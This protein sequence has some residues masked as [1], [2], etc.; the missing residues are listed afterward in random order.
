MCSRCYSGGALLQVNDENV[1]LDCITTHQ[2]APILTELQREKLIADCECIPYSR[3]QKSLSLV[4]SIRLNGF[5][6][7][8]NIRYYTF[9]DLVFYDSPERPVARLFY[10]H[11]IMWF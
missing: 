1:C 9:G 3:I 4:S 6:V 2:I 5:F 8:D 10:N 7:Q 11:L